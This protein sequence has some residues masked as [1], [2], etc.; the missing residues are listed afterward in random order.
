MDNKPFGVKFITN[1]R[2]LLQSVNATITVTITTKHDWRVAVG[3]WLIKIGA[4][5]AGLGYKEKDVDN[6]QL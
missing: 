6:G 1:D 5:L 2:K 3:L 4:R